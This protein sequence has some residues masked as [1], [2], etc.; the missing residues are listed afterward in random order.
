MAR[1]DNLEF[2]FSGIKTQVAAY[3]KA[4]GPLD[5]DATADVCAGFQAAVTRVLAE[6]L[7]RAA[8]QER[9]RSVVLGGGVAANRELRRR[10]EE[11]AAKSGLRAFVPP[12]ASCTDNAAMIAYAGAARLVDGEHDPWDLV[13]TSA[14]VL[15][16]VTRKGRG[17]R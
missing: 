3:V 5:P 2:S 8:V 17:A 6:K 4:H 12:L 1:R 16:R 7:V 15:P 11:L 13:A 9:V 10:V 14:T